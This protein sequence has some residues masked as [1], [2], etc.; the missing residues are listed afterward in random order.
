[1]HDEVLLVACIAFE[2]E[3]TCSRT[4][5][6]IHVSTAASRTQST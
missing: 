4:Y 2:I 5:S 3:N 1:M 6:S